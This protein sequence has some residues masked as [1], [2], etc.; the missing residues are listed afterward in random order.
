[1]SYI[2]SP[3]CRCELMRVMVLTDQ[4]QGQCAEEHCCPPGQVCPLKDCFENG[5]VPAEIAL[6]QSAA[7]KKPGR[8]GG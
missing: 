1:M 5:S 8:K 4:T 7:G 3:M 6:A 2:D